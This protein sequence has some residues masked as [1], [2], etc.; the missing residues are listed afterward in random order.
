MILF[1]ICRWA[2][3][4]LS[5]SF[6]ISIFHSNNF[7]TSTWDCH[8]ITNSR[9]FILPKDFLLKNKSPVFRAQVIVCADVSLVT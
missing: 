4:F 9:L 6:F 3:I 2:T 8:C 5:R 1:I 7:L